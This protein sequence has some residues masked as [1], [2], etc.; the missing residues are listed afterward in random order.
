MKFSS[1][2]ITVYNFMSNVRV[3]TR[4]K[5]NYLNFGCGVHLDA[6]YGGVEKCCYGF[7]VGPTWGHGMNM[8]IASTWLT[9][10]RWLQALLLKSYDFGYKSYGKD[11]YANNES[12]LIGES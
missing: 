6:A 12:H 11:L 7:G 9:A 3:D 5:W 10:P 4:C 8:M 2:N 1:E